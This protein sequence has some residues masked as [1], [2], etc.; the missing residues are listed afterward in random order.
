MNQKHRNQV[1]ANAEAEHRVVERPAVLTVEDSS[2][3]ITPMSTPQA[4]WCEATKQ[5]TARGEDKPIWLMEPAEVN[6]LNGM[7]QH[8][9]GPS[10]HF[11]GGALHLY[12]P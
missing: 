6:M 8:N 5:I 12:H 11:L 3:A 9:L 4:G 2:S 7:M 10:K 1:K